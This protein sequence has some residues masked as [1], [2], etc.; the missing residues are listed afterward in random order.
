LGAAAEIRPVKSGKCLRFFLKTS[1]DV[2]KFAEAV[3]KLPTIEFLDDTES[4]DEEASD[5]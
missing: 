3:K 5:E 1:D 4:S 2:A